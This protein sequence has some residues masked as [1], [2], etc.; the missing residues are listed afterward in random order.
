VRRIG[1]NAESAKSRGAEGGTVTDA[2][3]DGQAAE[4]PVD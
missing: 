3:F 1:Q 4:P 2:A